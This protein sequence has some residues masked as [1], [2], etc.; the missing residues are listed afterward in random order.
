MVFELCSAGK[1][2]G[3]VYTTAHLTFDGDGAVTTL[4]SNTAGGKGG[5]V[6]ALGCDASLFVPFGHRLSVLGNAALDGGGLA[7]DRGGSIVLEAEICGLPGCLPPMIGDGNCDAVCMSRG[8]NWRV[9][10]NFGRPRT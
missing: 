7:F 10:P 1:D 6:M 8:C 9:A 3:A 4:R 5:A 2:G